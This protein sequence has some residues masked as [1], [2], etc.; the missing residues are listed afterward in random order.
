MVQFLSSGLSLTNTEISTKS[1][2]TEMLFWDWFGHIL[3]LLAN[4]R[5][6]IL[7]FEYTVAS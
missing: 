5:N 7:A 2:L 3:G 6:E 1:S 4:G